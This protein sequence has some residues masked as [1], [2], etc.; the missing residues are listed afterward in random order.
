MLI[1]L[2][3]YII[4]S[5]IIIGDI[6]QNNIYT[7]KFNSSK[8]YTPSNIEIKTLKAD[9]NRFI[10]IS[11]YFMRIH[12]VDNKDDLKESISYFMDVAFKKITASKYIDSRLYELYAMEDILKNPSIIDRFYPEIQNTPNTHSLYT[13]NSTRSRRLVLVNA[14]D[15]IKKLEQFAK[16]ND[17]T[18]NTKLENIV[19]QAE[20]PKKIKD[21]IKLAIKMLNQKTM[22]DKLLTML[23]I[24]K[25]QDETYIKNN[26]IES[27][28]AIYEFL[29]MLGFTRGYLTAYNT[30]K[31]KYG[32]P[33]L[34]YAY[35]RDNE[36]NSMSIQEVFSNEYLQ[37]L[38]HRELCFLNAFW[39]NRFTKDCARLNSAFSAINSLD[40]WDSI[41]KGK[42]E[43]SISDEAAT[44]VLQK[45]NFISGLMRDTFQILQQNI[46][47]A[48][49]KQGTNFDGNVSQD[50]SAYYTKI[51]NA[52]KNDYNTYFKDK[53]LIS[54]DFL[55]DV[56][57]A[58]PF[59]NL[60]MFVYH[61]KNTTLEPL[62]K[63]TLD[64][65]N[66]KNWGI[67]RDELDNGTFVDSLSTNRAMVLLGFDVEGF[68]MPFR[69]HI[70]KDTL[71]ELSKLSN[72][73]Y[74]V[75]EYQGNE[76]FM[77]YNITERRLE[78]IPTNIM[79]PI[80]K[81][82]RKIII[83]KA[84]SDIQNK[85]L[86]EHFYFLMNGTFP[87]HL[88]QTVQKSKKQTITT[89]LPIIYTDLKTG[90]RFIKDKNR[91]I[92]INDDNVR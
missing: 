63:N 77:A 60:E 62:I 40:L 50:Y 9:I 89:R 71:M 78:I 6:M 49:L 16:D 75:P 88:T 39:C 33:E 25:E 51:N 36:N 79:M 56:S 41:L 24:Q 47:S 59:T 84:N 19:V 61:K 15:E 86:W 44:A 73:S 67:I 32:F 1:C 8:K 14:L 42:S 10:P 2:L 12:N 80:P 18:A 55:D 69:F 92:D 82:H 46:Y 28:T 53:L 11:K 85:N 27:L 76:D 23:K 65:N 21:I 37:T 83:D 30:T 52:I 58:A 20:D 3:F 90:K 74:I 29:N 45:S 34:D 57:F 43:F 66:C 87:K 35:S 13:A 48:E 68:N 22:R 26:Q 81:E 54:N 70:S 31:T 72:S 4:N 7:Q 64:N 5:I 38:S 91:F 17:I